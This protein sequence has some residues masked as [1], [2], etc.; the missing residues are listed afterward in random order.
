MACQHI[1]ADEFL[2]IVMPTIGRGDVTATAAAVQAR[3]E[4][5]Q[6][7]QLLGDSRPDVRRVAAVTLGL[8]GNMSVCA[9]LARTLG[10]PDEQ[11]TQMAEHS[12]LAIWFRAG[13]PEATQAFKE[14]MALLASEAYQK[15]ILHFDQAIGIDPRFAEAYN[16]A[17]IA[18]FFMHDWDRSIDYC[19]RAVELTPQHFGA[20]AGMGHCY[21]HKGVLDKALGCYRK[22]IAIHP[23]L[24]AVRRLI[25]QLENRQRAANEWSGV[26][27]AWR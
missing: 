22:A 9:C 14:G 5:R 19:R 1:D 16:Q 24:N 10:D 18:C 8:V 15:A 13:K 3:W 27:A 25:E 4:P 6:L 26:Y 23:H 12:L 11:V 20:M 21:T 7:C 17:G 2:R